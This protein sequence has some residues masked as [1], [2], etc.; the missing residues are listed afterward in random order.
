MQDL[1]Q[2]TQVR[3]SMVGIVSVLASSKADT[4]C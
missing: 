4:G 3:R 2:R 1:R